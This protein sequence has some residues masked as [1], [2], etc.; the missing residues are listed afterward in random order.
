MRQ[1]ATLFIFGFALLLV[2]LVFFTKSFAIVQRVAVVDLVTGS[3]RV[4]VHGRGELVPLQVGRLVRAGDVVRTGPDS[5]VELRWVRWAGGARIKLGP[6][7]TFTVKRAVRNRST[8]KEESRLR[9]DEGTLWIRLRKALRG[10]S[11]FEVETPTAVAAV[12]GTVFR[13][14]VAPDGTSRISVWEGAV[15]VTA[16]GREEITISGGHSAAVGSQVEAAAPRALSPAEEDEWLTHASI[17]GP[18]LAVDSPEDGATLAEGAVVVSGRAEPDCRVFVEGQP[19]PLSRD[20]AFSLSVALDEGANV[21]HVT[22]EADDGR[23]TT[24]TR[25]LVVMPAPQAAPAQPQ[26]R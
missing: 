1:A 4:Q 25:D 9:V 16:E 7:T 19:V 22:A 21:L 8:G 10:K 12:R 24:S 20:G 2:F 13:V 26:P 6:N 11:K 18:F 23:Q 17:L 3:G 14:A 5:S 15:S